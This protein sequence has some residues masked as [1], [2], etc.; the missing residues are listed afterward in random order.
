MLHWGFTLKLT[1]SEGAVWVRYY[2]PYKIEYNAKAKYDHKTQKDNMAKELRNLHVWIM[3]ISRWMHDKHKCFSGGLSDNESYDIMSFVHAFCEI[4]T[5]N[6]TRWH[7][8]S[9]GSRHCFF[10]KHVIAHCPFFP[11]RPGLDH[12][13]SLSTSFTKDLWNLLCPL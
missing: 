6:A 8:S 10:Y 12:T 7:A 5:C 13:F 2:F 1:N 3:I 11:L 9:S 4:P